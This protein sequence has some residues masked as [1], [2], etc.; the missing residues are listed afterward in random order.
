[1]GLWLGVI[2]IRKRTFCLYCMLSLL[3]L[4]AV[5]MPGCLVEACPKPHHNSFKLR[6]IIE[7]NPLCYSKYEKMN[8]KNLALVSSLRLIH[9]FPC[10]LVFWLLFSNFFNYKIVITIEAAKDSR[11][12]CK[13]F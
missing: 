13:S 10:H 9:V 12:I 3:Q 6:D 4:K 8:L 1:M 7:E 5:S 11:E 2:E